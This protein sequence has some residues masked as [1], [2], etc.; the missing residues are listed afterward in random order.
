MAFRPLLLCLTIA[1]MAR[2]AVAD[3]D[4]ALTG[5]WFHFAPYSYIETEQGFPLWKGFDVELVSEIAKR[6]GYAVS[7][8]GENTWSDLMQGIE[9]GDV[10]IV[11]AATRTPEREAFAYFSDPYRTD[12]VALILPKGMSA[13][14][15]A[16]TDVE[17]VDLFKQKSLRLGVEAGAAFPSQAVRLFLADPANADRIVVQKSVHDLLQRLRDGHIDGYLTDRIVAATFIRANDAADEVEEHPL[18]LDGD[19]HLMFSRASVA[20]DVVAAFNR[21]IRS[22][23]D[24]GTF[25]RVN[26]A[27]VFPILVTLT[28]DSDWFF[29]VDIIGTIAFALSGLLLAIRYNYDI[30][31][32]LVLASLPA[33]GGGVLRDLLTNRDTLAV[34][35]DPIYVEVIIILVAG[36]LLIFRLGV[37]LRRRGALSRAFNHLDRRR[38]QV[39]LLVQIFDAVGLAAFTVTGVVVAIATRSNPLWLWGP[40]LAAITA[41]GG[42]ILRDVVR[43]DPDIPTLKGELY[44]EIAL[45]WGF[46]LSLFMTWQMRHLHAG[47]IAAGMIATFVGA[48]VTRIAT[49]HFGIRSPR[50]SLKP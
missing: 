5:G 13:S 38:D 41:A 40:I 45:V 34:L 15:P 49:I 18:L 25:R 35:A 7:F 33:V 39:G 32:A 48:F 46:V 28:L 23:H 22:V 47:E 43:S 6:A 9:R 30:F 2:P 4:Q 3:N 21:A 8:P 50:F 1:L 27:Y 24:N 36:G 17:L 11:A 16:A 26:E 44:P 37:A 10:D 19:I 12:T 29:I 31:G 20:P 42:G 14:L